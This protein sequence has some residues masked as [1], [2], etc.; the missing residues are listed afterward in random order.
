MGR[1]RTPAKETSAPIENAAPGASEWEAAIRSLNLAPQ[2]ARVV[3]MVLLGKKDKE[4]AAALGLHKSTVRTYLGRVF[5][6][7][8]V[9]DR[10]GLAVSI[11]NSCLAARQGDERHHK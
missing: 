2:E 3:E 9:S 7:L 5:I 11:F 8:G 10:M 4:I 6:R 1:Q